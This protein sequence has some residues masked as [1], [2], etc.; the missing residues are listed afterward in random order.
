MI[1]REDRHDVRGLVDLVDNAKVASASA[2]LA[3]EVESEGSAD[4]SRV[5]RQTAVHELDAG[6]RDLLGQAIE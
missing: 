2:V 6:G 3:F 5:L 1:D 4:T